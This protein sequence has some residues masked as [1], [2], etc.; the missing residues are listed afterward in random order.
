MDSVGVKI[1]GAE[2]LILKGE[3]GDPGEPGTNTPVPGPDGKDGKDG[4]PG[5]DGKDGRNGFDGRHGTDGKDGVNG[6]PGLRGKDG[7]PDTGEEIIQKINK[8]KSDRLIRKDKVEGMAEF[9]KLARTA[10]SN[11]RSWGGSGSFVYAQD[12]SDQLNGTLKTFSLVPN[13]HV[14]MVFGSSTPGVFRPTVDYTTI[15]S[16]ITFTSQIDETSTLATGQT[17]IILYKIL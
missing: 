9:E 4:T 3:K 13:A 11:V 5:R 1:E 16:S 7:S 14:I 6:I 15:A 17:V 10:D 8:D 12:I 2:V